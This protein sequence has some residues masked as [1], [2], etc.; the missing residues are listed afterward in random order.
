V[1]TVT[2]VLLVITGFAL[3][4]PDAWWVRWLGDIGLT[5]PLRLNLHRVSAVGLIL[6]GLSHLWYVFLT[7]RGKKEFR[8][9]LPSLADVRDLIQNLRYYTWRTDRK[10]RFGRYDYSQKAEYWALMW[11][12][13]IMVVT[14]VILWFPVQAARFLPAVL[15]P[16]AQTIHYYEAWLATLA[17]IVWH[18]FFVIFHPEEYPMSWTWLTGRISK[19]SV[20]EHHPRWYEEETGKQAE[21]KA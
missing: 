1:L 6:V 11:G 13:V 15:I 14:G 4:F 3:R 8:S 7:R 9:I 16:A 18:F 20:E 12:S 2:F 5:E 17:I 21:D 19:K 10:A